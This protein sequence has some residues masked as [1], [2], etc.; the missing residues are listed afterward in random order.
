M[1]FEI[2]VLIVLFLFFFLELVRRGADVNAVSNLDYDIQYKDT[3]L[4][5]AIALNKQETIKLLCSSGARRQ[6]YITI[7]IPR[8]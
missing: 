5:R 3:P 7:F 1:V 6:K 2:A 8:R 4:H